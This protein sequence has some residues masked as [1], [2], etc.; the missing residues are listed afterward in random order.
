MPAVLIHTSDIEATGAIQPGSRVSFRLF[1]NGDDTKLKA[2]QDSVE[3][4]PSDRWR[5]Q[6][7]ASRT[8]D[9]FESTTQYLSLTVAIVVIMAATTLV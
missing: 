1:L 2:T 5:T 9:M 4:T 3:L 7:S 6:D 8:N